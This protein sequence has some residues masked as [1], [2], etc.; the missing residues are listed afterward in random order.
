MDIVSFCREARIVILDGKIWLVCVTEWKV[1]QFIISV[2]S[3]RVLLSTLF[4]NTLRAIIIKTLRDNLHWELNHLYLKSLKIRFRILFHS[5]IHSCGGGESLHFYFEKISNLQESCKNGIMNS[6]AY[7]FCV[8][9][10][11]IETLPYL[12]YLSI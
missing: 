4:C 6:F 1:A 12:L 2:N 5:E 3:F 8:D 7:T 10:W 11:V 9:L